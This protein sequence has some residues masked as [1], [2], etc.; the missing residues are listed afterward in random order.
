MKNSLRGV[1]QQQSEERCPEFFTKKQG[2]TWP[3][4]TFPF[5]DCP[6]GPSSA[7]PNGYTI[8]RPLIWVGLK[9]GGRSIPNVFSSISDTGCDYC[10]FPADYLDP[11]GIDTKGLPCGDVKGMGEHHPFYFSNVTLWV[12]GLGEW[13]VYAGFSEYLRGTQSGFLGF[14]GFVDRFRIE[15]DCS[16]KHVSV[17]PLT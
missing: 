9:Y 15:F 10:V 16:L 17:F 3:M 11:L 13:E 12:D 5:T 8:S 7:F 1:Y 14:R 4:P 2:H 6:V